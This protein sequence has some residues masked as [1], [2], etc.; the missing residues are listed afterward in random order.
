MIQEFLI[1]SK[2]KD[3]LKVDSFFKELVDNKG[4]KDR[5]RIFLVCP[6]VFMF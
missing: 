2:Q 3:G 6:Q 4:K 5:L 1:Y